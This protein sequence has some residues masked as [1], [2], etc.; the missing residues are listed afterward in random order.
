VTSLRCVWIFNHDLI[1]D[2]LLISHY[3]RVLYRS[4]AL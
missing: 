3:Y 1:T 2:L 4:L